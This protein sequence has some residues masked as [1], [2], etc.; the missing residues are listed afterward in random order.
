VVVH[1]AH[2][3]GQTYFMRLDGNTIDTMSSVLLRAGSTI[4]LS[5]GTVPTAWY[6]TRA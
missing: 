4:Y 5:Y 2:V 6:W 3:A 1:T